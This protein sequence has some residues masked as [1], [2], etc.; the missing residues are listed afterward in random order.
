MKKVLWA[1]TVTMLFGFVGLV[2]GE[3]T[4]NTTWEIPERGAAV[5]FREGDRA[6]AIG[7]QSGGAGSAAQPIPPEYLMPGEGGQPVPNSRCMM[8]TD[9]CSGVCV[10][11][12]NYYCKNSDCGKM[13]FC[14]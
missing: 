5:T 4:D 8:Q 6:F 13:R 2:E 3:T 7:A 9:G 10:N 11:S 14:G 12:M 1:L